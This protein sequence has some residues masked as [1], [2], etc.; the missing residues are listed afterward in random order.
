MISLAVPH[1]RRAV[2]PLALVDVPALSLSPKPI[3]VSM[4]YMFRE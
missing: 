1:V 3:L 4:T 2:G